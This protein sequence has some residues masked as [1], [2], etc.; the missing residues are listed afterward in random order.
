MAQVNSTSQQN[1]GIKIAQLG[2]DARTAAD[3]N[4]L[5]SSSWPLLKI[6]YTDSVSVPANSTYTYAHNFGFP[7]FHFGPTD[8][9]NSPLT[10]LQ[11]KVDSTNLYIING[12]ATAQTARFY[13][14]YN[15]LNI[16]FQALDNQNYQLYTAQPYDKN[17]GIK[18]V[19]QNKNINSTDLRDFTVHSGT[20]SLMIEGIVSG[21]LANEPILPGGNFNTVFYQ[22]KLPYPSLYF[23]FWSPDG[24]TYNFLSGFGQSGPK[25][26]RGTA[27][28]IKYTETMW[29]LPK[30][31]TPSQTGCIYVFKDPFIAANPIQ[32]SY[33]G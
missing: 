14:C 8:D 19:K 22:S 4:L 20:R 1:Y 26:A 16:N 6:A 24:I 15:P 10:L 32:V 31:N 11:T 13:L 21:I 23:G 25:M 18:I 3:Q 33:S 12:N 7:P 2:Y 28:T 17:Y 5:F 9:N 29:I 30:L 27:Y